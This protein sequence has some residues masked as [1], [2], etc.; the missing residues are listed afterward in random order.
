M[1]LRCAAVSLCLVCSVLIPPVT[2]A[3]PLADLD[4]GWFTEHPVS[5]V[6]GRDPFLPKVRTSGA[7]KGAAP[8]FLLT[9]V[10]EGK[11]GPTAVVNGSIV[12]VGDTIRGNKVLVIKSKSIILR[13]ASGKR[14]V[15]L[16]PLFATNNDTP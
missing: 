3:V 13:G 7:G 4:T 2:V 6:W 10:L 15:H 5:Q 8:P 14:E 11:E 16:K 1:S 12:R 9:A